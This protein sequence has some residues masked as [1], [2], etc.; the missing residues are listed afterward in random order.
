MAADAWSKSIVGSVGNGGTFSSCKTPGIYSIGI[1]KPDSVSDFPK[2]NGSPIYSWGMMIVT[3]SQGCTSQFYMSHKGHMAVRQLW[4]PSKEYHEWFVQ[5][6][7][8]NKPSATDIGALP[9]TG[10]SLNGSISSSVMDNY[11]IE[12]GGYGVFLRLD[13]ENFYILQTNK[14]DSKGSWN[15]FRPFSINMKTG[16]VLLDHE[17]KINGNLLIGSTGT[18]IAQDGNIWGSRW[19]N[20]WLWDAVVELVNNRTN[21][22][23]NTAQKEPNGWWK[24]GDT[25]MIIQWGIFGQGKGD[26]TYTLPLPMKFP[27][28][29]LWALGYAGQALHYTADAYSGSAV[30]ADNANLRVTIDN[31]LP[32]VCIAIGY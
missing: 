20:K 30:L 9:I 32:T 17:T 26:G 27:N 21:A 2:V 16:K 13:G 4:Y 11:R 24:C 31:G 8:E 19:G 10:G 25:G 23:K 29:G 22:T 6:S 12:A 28:R 7:P 1:E 14:N 3:R 18:T 5:Y 15:N